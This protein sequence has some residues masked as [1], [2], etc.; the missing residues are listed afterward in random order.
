[1][2]ELM[3]QSPVSSRLPLEIGGVTLALAEPGRVTWVAVRDDGALASALEEEVGCGLPT[4]L[5][6]TTASG[7][8]LVWHG[9]GQVLAIG[10]LPSALAGLPMT[11]QSDGFAC[12]ALSG[13]GARDVLARLTPVDLRGHVFPVDGA[14][15][16]LLG[17]MTATLIREGDAAWLC[18]VPRS[19]ADSAVHDLTR[20]MEGVAG[21]AT[22]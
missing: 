2:V 21:R 8:R 22:L 19:M 14:A 18:L 6:S 10:A 13:H 20:A 7:L 5:R 4:A 17:H 11:D 15:R 12:L 3:A 1:M 9:P 16:T